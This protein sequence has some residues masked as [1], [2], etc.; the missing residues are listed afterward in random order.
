MTVELHF[1]GASRTV[2]GS[3]FQLRTDRARI[4]VDCGMFQGPKTEKELNYRP[5]PFGPGSVDALLLT[6]A[7]IDHSGLV[8]KLVKAGFEGRIFATRAT[9]DLCSVM[10]PD[11]GFI[12]EMEVEQLNRRNARRG[13]AEVEPIYTAADADQAMLQFTPVAYEAW[14]EVADGIRARYWNAGHLLGS[15]S[16]EVEVAA[17]AKPLRILFSGDIGPDHKLLQF[18]P[19]APAGWD[20]V[21]CESTYG[22]EERHDASPERRRRLLKEEVEGAERRG[23]ALVIPSFAVER[24]QELLTDLVELMERGEVRRAPI[25]IDSP[26]ATKASAIFESHASEIEDGPLLRRAMSAENVRFTESVEQS[27]GIDRLTGF[28]IVIAASGMCEA[29]RIRHHLKARLW[30][31]EA[32]VLIVGYQAQGTLGRILQEGAKRVRIMGEEIEVRAQIRTLDVYSGHAD[33]PQLRRWIEKRLPIRH[34]LFL[35]HGE[36]EA[37]SGLKGRAAQLMPE[38]H[39]VV[40]ALDDV[41]GLTRDGLRV[42]DRQGKRRILPTQTAQLDW[43]NDLSKLL[44]DIGET[45]DHAADDRARGVIIRRLRRALEETETETGNGP[46]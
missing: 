19:E 16:I 35:V 40:P 27:K 8:P 24:T 11:S 26:L 32:T 39:V 45:M 1:H 23:G 7:H 13:R 46:A 44:L 43:H 37:L 20:Y 5:F 12:Q 34:G 25:F 9:R 18:D 30:R 17:G 41:F 22:D 2:T 4:L 14:T 28:H 10:L 15:A 36:E 31:R 38:E 33:G 6:H 21:V 29:G 3:C 42:P